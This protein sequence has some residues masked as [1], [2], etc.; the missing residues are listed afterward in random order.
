MVPTSAAL[1][2]PQTPWLRACGLFL[3]AML[4]LAT[5]DMLAKDLVGRHPA[6]LVNLVRYGVVVLLAAGL[7]RAQCASWRLPVEHRRLVFWRSVMLGTV[8]LTFMQALRWMP[9]AEA[10]ALY[11]LSPLI[12]VALSGW[13]LGERVGLRQWAA[14]LAGFAGMLLIVRPGGALPLAG[15]ALM[16]MAASAYALLQVLTR[17]LAGR[18]G[19]APQF[20]WAAVVCFG[21]TLVSLPTAGALAWPSAADLAWM[22]LVGL[23]SA[24]GQYLLI[25]AFQ[26]VPASSLAPFNYFHLLL[27]VAFSVAVFDQRPDALALA[28]MVTI[29]GAGLA[30]T[31]PMFRQQLASA[32]AQ[33]A[34]R[35]VG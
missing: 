27:A 30:L 29:A 7:M 2:A 8:G 28:G 18:V 34:A 13:L 9:L 20:F 6:P 15:T 32:A 22:V 17:R 11:F 26:Q 35:R 14:V 31:L 33:R 25:R 21:M 10:T 16:L 19:M 3:C 23:L 24:V 12:V 4:A 5:L 1:P